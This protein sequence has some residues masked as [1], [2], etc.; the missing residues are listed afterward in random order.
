MLDV[1]SR[2]AWQT[3]S[4]WGQLRCPLADGVDGWRDDMMEAGWLVDSCLGLSH[5]HAAL[6]LCV[7]C[8]A[9]ATV[10]KKKKKDL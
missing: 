2:S 5:H 6:G 1:S 7:A 3:E 9:S 10:E 4:L 8:L